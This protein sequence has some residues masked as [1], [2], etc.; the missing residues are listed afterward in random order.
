MAK[1]RFSELLAAESILTAGTKTMDINVTDPITALGIQFRLTN[2]DSAPDGHPVKAATRIEVVDGSDV[3]LSVKGIGAQAV[4]FLGHGHQ[5]FNLLSYIDNNQ[6]IATVLLFFGRYLWDEEF[7]LDPAR[8]NNLQLKI[9]HNY[10]LGGSSVDAATMQVYALLFDKMPPALKGLI[11]TK[12]IYAYA[13]ASSGVE[14]VELPTDKL[15]RALFVQSLS[16]AKQPHEQYNKLKLSEDFDK[17]VHFDGSVSNLFKF[18]PYNERLFHEQL[19]IASSGST[20]EFY[21]TPAYEVAVGGVE[22]LQGASYLK[23]LRSYGGTIDLVG[24]A[25]DEFTVN[26]SGKAPHGALI[27]PF[28]DL[29]YPPDWFDPTGLKSARLQITAGSSVGSSS[30]LEL[31]AQQV[32]MY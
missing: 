5:P 19:F 3:L 17:S 12:E 2:G 7:G 23:A 10:A 8:F 30:T 21:C 24:S 4:E 16:D 26:L 9:A 1:H 11:T 31:I 15:I 18:L 13:L 20:D 25:A 29:D 14:Y 28:G 6:C 32:R 22:S 27:I